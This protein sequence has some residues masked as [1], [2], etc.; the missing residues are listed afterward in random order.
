MRDLINLI[1]LK[2]NA[3]SVP[4]TFPLL[5]KALMRLLIFKI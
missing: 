2:K 3:L 4:L 1:K 5:E